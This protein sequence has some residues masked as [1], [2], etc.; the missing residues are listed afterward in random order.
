M[1]AM[2]SL[3]VAVTVLTP[4]AGGKEKEGPD[5]ASL[6]KA[7]READAVFTAKVK[8]VNPQGM[9]NSIPAT[10]FGTV[11]FKDVKPVRGAAPEGLTFSYS[12]REGASK[13]LNLA[14]TVPVVVAT[15]QKAVT[16]IVP[17]TEANL[18]LAA[19]GAKQK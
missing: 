14:A 1:R 5:Q 8:E 11:T 6:A 13:H 10:V 18:A 2:T 19:K 9:T 15:R 12:Y 7:F 17:A 16:V 4:L 3:V